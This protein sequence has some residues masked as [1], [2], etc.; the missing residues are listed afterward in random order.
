[1]VRIRLK[2]TGTRNRSCFRVVVMDQRST[3]DGR[4]IEEIGFYDPNQEE[5]R[6]T[7][8]RYE[9]W[10]ANGAQPSKTV[11]DIARRIKNGTSTAK[12]TTEESESTPT[13]EPVAKEVVP[14]T[15]TQEEPKT[16]APVEADT[17]EEAPAEEV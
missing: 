17:K 12:T 10:L 8:D 3:R 4:S 9:Y 15:D 14:A 11:A 7:L 1:M 16:D 13:E 2:R 5:E 6:L